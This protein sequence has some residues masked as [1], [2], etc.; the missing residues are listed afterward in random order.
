MEDAV[1]DRFSMDANGRLVPVPARVPSH[2]LENQW[3]VISMYMAEPV[4]ACKLTRDGF[5]H[6]EEVMH[7]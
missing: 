6:V 4:I 5:P 2:V 1:E 7:E 3:C